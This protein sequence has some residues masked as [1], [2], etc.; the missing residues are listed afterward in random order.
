MELAL[1]QFI[2]L[3]PTSVWKIAPLFKGI[4]VAM[5]FICCVAA[6]YFQLI[7]SW[8]LMYVLNSLKYTLPWA[9]CGNSW[10]TDGK[11]F[12]LR[13]FCYSFDS[14][15][16]CF[17][18]CSVWN[19]GAVENCRVMNGTILANGTCSFNIPKSNVTTDLENFPKNSVLP[20][21]EY[22]Q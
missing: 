13:K 5:V 3:G 1:G 11:Q 22:F 4:G 21:L 20:S 10:N 12:Y 18:A 19:K 8:S 16:N 9:T 2:S 14:Y 6:I 7:T 15:V 17:L